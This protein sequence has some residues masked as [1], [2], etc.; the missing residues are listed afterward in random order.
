MNSKLFTLLA[1][2]TGTVIFGSCKKQVD[3]CTDPSADNYNLNATDDDGSCLYSK[4]VG[5]SFGGGII[6][7]VDISGQHGLIAAPSDLGD[8][9]RWDDGSNA[10]TYVTNTLLFSGDNNTTQIVAIYGDGDYAAKQ[11]EDL[12][13][14][15]FTDWYLPS[16]SE[17]E[18]LYEFRVQVGGFSDD[19][20]W[21]SSEN[22]N[23]DYRFLAFRVN[24]GT[25]LSSTFYKNFKARVRPIRAF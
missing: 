1:L 18:E 20:Y 9:A 22:S 13:L 15:G 4:H 11:C 16:K 10:D 7:Y 21:T 3:G 5:E 25:G 2:I 8:S 14:N 19:Y 24:F 12:E 17:L 6:F 23:E